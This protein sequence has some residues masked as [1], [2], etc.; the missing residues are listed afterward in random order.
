MIYRFDAHLNLKLQLVAKKLIHCTRTHFEITMKN[1]FLLPVFVIAFMCNTTIAFGQDTSVKVE[2]TK[3]ASIEEEEAGPS[4]FKFEPNFLDS[5][6]KRREE[7][8][9]TRSIIDTLKI[10]DTRRKKLLRDLYKNGLTRRLSK[11]IIAESH[12]EDTASENK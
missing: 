7:M 9:R 3:K 8:A 4:M 10:S 6:E 2:K 11:I 1:L 12:F 5:K